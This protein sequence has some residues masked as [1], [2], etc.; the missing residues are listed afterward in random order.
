MFCSWFKSVILSILVAAVRADTGWT[1]PCLLIPR[2]KRGPE[3]RQAHGL[4][5]QL[6]VLSS[7]HVVK[8]A[9]ATI[10]S[11]TTFFIQFFESDGRG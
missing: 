11:L 4:H 8:A 9:A 10:L 6:V 2:L 1:A 7:C 5:E 3:R